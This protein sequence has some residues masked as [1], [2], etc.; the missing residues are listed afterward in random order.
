MTKR[1]VIKFGGADLSTGE[2]IKRAA[3]LVAESGY[4]EVAVVVSAMGKTTNQLIDTISKIGNLSD[5][6][7]AEIVSMGERISVR[8]FCSALTSKKINAEYFDPS[9]KKWPIITD[10]D[11]LNAK[12]DIEETKKRVQNYVEPL[13]GDIIPVVCGFLGRNR[14]GDTTTLGR[15][16]SDITAL[17]LANCLEADEIILV[18][19]TEGVLS[20]DPNIVPNAKILKRLD[21]Y[22]LFTLAMGGARIIRSQ[23]LKYK[24]ENQKLRI[25]SFFSKNISKGGTEIIGTFNPDH[26]KIQKHT[27]LTAVTVVCRIDSKF[28]SNVFSTLQGESIYGISTG[29]ESI[30]IFIKIDNINE[31]INLIH[32]LGHLKA[33]SHQD[34]LAMIELTHPSFV[35]SPGWI[36]KI[37]GALASR[38]INITEVTTSKATINIFIDRMITEDAMQAV[39]E[40]FQ[41]S[42]LRT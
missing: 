38:N 24:L 6:D 10:S 16:G 32:D 33:I 7:Y 23:A 29:R 36:A 9:N 8:V 17:L 11:F 39:N 14:Q 4:Q 19:E 5:H 35:D 30:T 15:G 31:I 21:I 25:A 3:M 12:I 42:L 27:D 1:A 34:N 40:V 22:E 28:L 13:L 37:T 41:G 18:K 26:I 2:R 20:A